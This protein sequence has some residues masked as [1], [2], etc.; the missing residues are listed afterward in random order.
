[1]LFEFMEGVNTK[2]ILIVITWVNK[3]FL[4]SWK[5]P[6]KRIILLNSTK[7]STAKKKLGA[8]KT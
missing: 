5:A 4:K 6:I 2:V 8:E 1:M 7:N 3:H